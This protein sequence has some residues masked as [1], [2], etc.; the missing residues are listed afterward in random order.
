[1]KNFIV[2]GMDRCGKTTLIKKLPLLM[3]LQE[4]IIAI[5]HPA[6]HFAE[7]CKNTRDEQIIRYNKRLYMST[8]DTSVYLNETGN[9]VIWD[10]SHLSEFVYGSLYRGYDSTYAM[11]SEFN[12][13]FAQFAEKTTLIVL[14]DGPE[15]IINR[16]DG[17]SN[18]IDEDKLVEE[19]LR[20][21][22]AFQRSM[23]RKKI[24]INIH[25]KS[26]TEVYNLIGRHQRAQ[27]NKNGDIVN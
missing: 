26:M 11:E 7:E 4:P 20:F 6:R 21:L 18:S 25:D 12:L 10:R 22:D 8:Y 5:K 2:D 15:G 14:V 19:R 3:N 24:Y 17:E 9:Q 1:M 27:F 13:H 16:D 23:I